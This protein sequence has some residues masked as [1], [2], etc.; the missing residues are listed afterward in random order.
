M[1]PHATPRAHWGRLGSNFGAGRFVE[2]YLMRFGAETGEETWIIR[3]T[4]T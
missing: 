2:D 4:Q 1:A 3:C